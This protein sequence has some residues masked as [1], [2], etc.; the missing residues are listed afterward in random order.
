MCPDTSSSHRL[1]H[2]S[3]PRL[4]PL[5]FESLECGTELAQ[6]HDMA[7]RARGAQHENMLRAREGAYMPATWMRQGGL[8]VVVLLL[9]PLL[10]VAQPRAREAR[11]DRS[12]DRASS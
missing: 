9:T 3:I 4:P 11:P 12:P 7:P 8:V 2:D 1:E 10:A 5:L 6:Q